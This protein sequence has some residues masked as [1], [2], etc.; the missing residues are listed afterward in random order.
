M[1]KFSCGR[2][3]KGQSSSKPASLCDPRFSL[4]LQTNEQSLRDLGLSE[5]LDLKFQ[6]K[7]QTL[8]QISSTRAAW[9]GSGSHEGIGGESPTGTRLLGRRV[10]PEGEGRG[11]GWMPKGLFPISSFSVIGWRQDGSVFFYTPEKV[12]RHCRKRMKTHK[13]LAC[14]LQPLGSPRGSGVL[15]VVGKKRESLRSPWN[16]SAPSGCR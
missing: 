1:P 16:N 5:P 12:S 8:C 3:Q 13:G 10:K 14:L 9:L 7:L 2:V 11:A 4:P 6:T 15:G